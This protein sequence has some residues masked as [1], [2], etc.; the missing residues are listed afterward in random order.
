[1]KTEGQIFRAK[2][3]YGLTWALGVVVGLYL[4][5]GLRALI[6]PTIVGA[7]SAYVCRPLL[8]EIRRFGVPHNLGVLI[9]VGLFCLGIAL[10]VSQVRSFIADEQAIL[11]LRVRGQYKLNERFAQVSARFPKW[12]VKEVEPFM[13]DLNKVVALGPG[14]Q[15]KFRTYR[16]GRRGVGRISAKFYGYH[17]ANLEFMKTLR[18]KELIR[19]KIGDKKLEI[20][21]GS[22]EEKAGGES[23]I[24]SAL[25]VL[26]IWVVMPFVFLFLLFDRGQTIKS[27][28]AFVP[29]KYFEVTLTVIHNVDKA[30]GAYLRGVTLECS[31]VGIT[32]AVCLLI[33]GLDLRVALLIGFIAGAANAIPFLGPAI[34]LVAGAA[35]ALVVEEIHPLIP[36]ITVDNLIVGVLITVAV[37]QG[38]DNA[39]FQPVVLGMVVDLHPLLVIFGVMGGSILFGMVGMLLAI[40]TIMIVKVVLTTLFRELRAYYII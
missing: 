30:L 23:F 34:G 19:G 28:V 9:L 32:F 18:E 25:G 21:R 5:W 1:M 16:E 29:N 2:V 12:A 37:A 11:V 4:V 10:I 17:V 7:M 38:L 35:Y 39:Y 36:F 24:A 40:P 27:L 14:E 13:A 26:S 8:R 15:E 33:C 22:P 20:A 31:L 6:L 3:L